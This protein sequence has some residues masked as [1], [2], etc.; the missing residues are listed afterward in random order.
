[1]GSGAAPGTATDGTPGATSA[2]TNWRLG[3]RYIAERRSP[4]GPHHLSGLG[5]YLASSKASL[6]L[7]RA[8]IDDALPSTRFSQHREEQVRTTATRRGELSEQVATQADLAATRRPA[9][10]G[11]THRGIGE[12]QPGERLQ[13]LV[14]S[15]QGTGPARLK[16]PQWMNSA[17]RRRYFT[18]PRHRL[19][20][21]RDA[22]RRRHRADEP[23]PP[24]RKAQSWRNRGPS[25]RRVP[26][27]PRSQLDEDARRTLRPRRAGDRTRR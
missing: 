15:L 8:S 7:S 26:A 5:G 21:V 16:A 23:Q 2:A 4:P 17:Q 22:A 24:R 13:A 6:E 20:R 10:A 25:R 19:K 1:M 18:Q 14:R 27:A 11:V 12:R 3:N 9:D